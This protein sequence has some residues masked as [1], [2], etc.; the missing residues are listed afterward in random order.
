MI[1]VSNNLYPTDNIKN[2]TIGTNDVEGV[3]CLTYYF[4]DET[5]LVP[6]T[7]YFNSKK[8][9]DKRVGELQGK[10]GRTLLG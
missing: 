9:L 5:K 1:Q 4:K 3:Y 2:I 10:K 8:D 7:E 6:V